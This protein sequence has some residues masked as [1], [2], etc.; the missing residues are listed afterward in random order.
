MNGG[1]IRSAASRSGSGLWSREFVHQKVSIT[2]FINNILISV[3]TVE[4][5]V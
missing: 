4:S 3:G 1:S 5:V 2:I